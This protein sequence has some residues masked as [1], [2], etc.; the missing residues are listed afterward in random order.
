MARMPKLLVVHVREPWGSRE[1]GRGR[2]QSALGG[3]E[4]SEGEARVPWGEGQ[5]EREKEKSSLRL[6]GWG[7]AAEGMDG[8]KEN[9]TKHL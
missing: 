2:G 8:G 1:E 6:Q 7:E 9:L 5:G 4:G 3:G